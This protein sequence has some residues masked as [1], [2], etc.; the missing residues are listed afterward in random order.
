MQT[1]D[2]AER[3]WG[4]A[5]ALA[6]FVP[7]VGMVMGAVLYTHADPEDRAAGVRVM[8]LA[9]FAGVCWTVAMFVIWLALIGITSSWG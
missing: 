8:L 9:F 1:N 5:Y 4:C 6:L 7:L 3:S 2:D